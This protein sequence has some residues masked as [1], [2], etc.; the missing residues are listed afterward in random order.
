MSTHSPPTDRSETDPA[1]TERTEITEIRQKLARNCEEI[2]TD[3][4]ELYNQIQA[5]IRESLSIPDGNVGS[6]V[7]S[8]L[9]E[10]KRGNKMRDHRGVEDPEAAFP[11]ACDGCEHYGVACPM[12]K[13]HSVTKTRERYI[14][15]AD[16]DEELVN[17]LTDLAIEWDCQVVLGVLEDYQDQYQ[18]YIAEGYDLH[19][20]MWGVLR[21][22][23]TGEDQ[24]EGVETSFDESPPPEVEADVQE[25]VDAVMGD[26]EDEADS[27]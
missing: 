2:R 12:V 15:N 3:D 22:E 24:L 13:R 27:Q 16:S 7:N 9:R 26:D 10:L 20:K 14:R 5:W 21:G 11:D 8:R 17:N 19:S 23:P 18:E 1:R 4:P 6:A 25:T